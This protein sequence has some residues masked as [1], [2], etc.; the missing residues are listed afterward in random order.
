MAA[1]T[2]CSDF[3]SPQNKVCHC[4]YCSPSICCEVMGPDAM[5]FIL[6]LF[7]YFVSSYNS[8]RKKKTDFRSK[9]SNTFLRLQ[10]FFMN[11]KK[12]IVP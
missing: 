9:I 1:A 12:L 5:L 2:I 8:L 7:N 3:Q 11:C 10:Y 4:F 6:V